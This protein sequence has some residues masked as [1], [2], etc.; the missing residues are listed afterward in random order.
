MLFLFFFVLSKIWWLFLLIP[1]AFFVFGGSKKWD[2][3][4]PSFIEVDAEKRKNDDLFYE[5]EKPKRREDSNYEI[6]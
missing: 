6:I 2:C 4:S 1:A 3:E 5:D